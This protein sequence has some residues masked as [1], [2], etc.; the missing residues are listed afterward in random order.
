MTEF[1]PLPIDEYFSEEATRSGLVLPDIHVST[2]L[3]GRMYRCGRTLDIAEDRLLNGSMEIQLDMPVPVYLDSRTQ[4]KSDP[5]RFDTV[6]TIDWPNRAWDRP[7]SARLAIHPNI[8]AIAAAEGAVRQMNAAF[9]T[10]VIA[11]RA[12]QENDGETRLSEEYHE[13]ESQ[14]DPLTFFNPAFLWRARMARKVGRQQYP[15][16]KYRKEGAELAEEY[17]VLGQGYIH[18]LRGSC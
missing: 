10:G 15:A 16:Y 9:W 3:A 5:S 17:P 4:D 8:N 1:S 14:P 11:V 6:L 13:L 2:M 18:P 12:L 7:A